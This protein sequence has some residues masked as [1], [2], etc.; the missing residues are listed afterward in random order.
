MSKYVVI[1]NNVVI[2]ETSD[3]NQ[4]YSKLI[5]TI[6]KTIKDNYGFFGVRCLPYSLD[7]YLN[8]SKE[9]VFNEELE[10][11]A[12][13]VLDLVDQV[14]RLDGSSIYKNNL[15]DLHLSNKEWDFGFKA[16]AGL[17]SVKSKDGFYYLKTNIFNNLKETN[18]FYFTFCLENVVATPDWQFGLGQVKKYGIALID[19]L[20]FEVDHFK[21][22]VLKK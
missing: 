19:I 7:T 12:N 15:I 6:T 13:D 22:E 4:G 1:E 21:K 18:Q 14:E 9:V 3:Y 2:I 16:K 17:M 8:I 20:N 11:L 10:E 5:N